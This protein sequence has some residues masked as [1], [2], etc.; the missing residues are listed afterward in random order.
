MAVQVRTDDIVTLD[1]ILLVTR[2]RL[3]KKIPCIHTHARAR[4]GGDSKNLALF[5]EGRER[6]IG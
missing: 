2:A 3:H 6:G 5:D 1:G 4:R